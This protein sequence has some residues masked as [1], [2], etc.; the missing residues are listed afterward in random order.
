MY[1]KNMKVEIRN[2]NKSYGSLKAVNNISFETESPNIFGLLGP[3]GAGK[4]TII[5][6]IMNILIPDKGEILFNDKHITEKDKDRIGYLPEERGLYKKVKVNDLLKYFAALKGKKNIQKNIDYWLD[7]FSLLEKKNKK[8]EELSKGMT[9]KIQ[10]IVAVLHDPDIIFLDEPFSG[11]DPVSTEIL[12]EAILELSKKDKTI[13]FSTHIME[14]AEK[15]CS[16]IFLINKG[17]E[18]LYGNLKDIKSSFGKNTVIIEFDGD[19]DIIKNSKIVSNMISYP[20]WIEAEIVDG[21]KPDDLLQEIVGKISIKRFE[22]LNPSLNK[23]FL[24]KIKDLH[25]K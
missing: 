18:V 14:E 12:R 13:L 16:N 19:I 2:L 23:I 6:M 9:Q 24:T 20:R 25:T 1:T 11:L 5:R 22:L 4:S 17:T 8:I 21:K 15:I 3:N 10:F 7:K